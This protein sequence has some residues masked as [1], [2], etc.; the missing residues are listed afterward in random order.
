MEGMHRGV[1]VAAAEIFEVLLLSFDRNEL[2][3]AVV[4][5]STGLVLSPPP[6]AI[7]PRPTYPPF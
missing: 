7:P 3:I 6:P 1:T 4:W 2:F 5:I